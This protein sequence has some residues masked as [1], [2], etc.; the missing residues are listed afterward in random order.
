MKCISPQCFLEDQ[1]RAICFAQELETLSRQ[2]HPFVLSLIG[3]CLDPPD[4]GWLVTEILTG[5]T[6]KEW[7]HGQGPRQRERLIPLPPLE[8]RIE[9]ALEI[10]QAMQYLHSQKPKILHRDLKP[11]NIFLD[12]A[13]HVKVADFGYACFL[14][15]G[16]KALTGETGEIYC[17]S[18]ARIMNALP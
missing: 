3:A 18:S 9:K 7:L 2:R 11:S 16:D 6:L 10:A 8:K 12:G 5:G 4:H 14:E 13:M 15:D 17:A 1:S